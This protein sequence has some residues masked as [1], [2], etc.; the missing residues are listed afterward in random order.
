VDFF[1]VGGFFSGVVA[2]CEGVDLLVFLKGVAG[3]LRGWA[4]FFGGE[5]VVRCMVDV[6][7]LV[8]GFLARKNAPAFRD[9]FSG[10]LMSRIK[11][12]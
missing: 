6:E 4:W 5:N 8:P 10:C 9:L 3:K 12:P 7:F 1:V 11:T 2:G